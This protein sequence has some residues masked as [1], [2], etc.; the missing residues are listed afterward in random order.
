MA[1]TLMDA[2]VLHEAACFLP[3][4]ANRDPEHF[5]DPN[6]FD[7]DR[8][9]AGDHT[10]FG[11]GAHFCIGAPLA[12]MEA[13]LAFQRLIGRARQLS[14]PKQEFKRAP[15]MVIRALQALRIELS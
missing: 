1:T 3:Q 9:N 5:P 14:L 2:D 7:I 6:R 13:R 15:S 12:R 4:V 8:P 11:F 10:S